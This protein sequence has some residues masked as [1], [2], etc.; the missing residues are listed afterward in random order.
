LRRIT[1]HLSVGQ[2]RVVLRTPKTNS[3]NRVLPIGS[4]EVIC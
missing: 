1:G 4:R 3:S 2:N